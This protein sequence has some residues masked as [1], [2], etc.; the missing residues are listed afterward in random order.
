MFVIPA[1]AGIQGR[2]IPSTTASTTLG[3]RFCRDDEHE[4]AC[5]IEQQSIADQASIA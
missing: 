5:G 4:I 1:N 3:S 2:C